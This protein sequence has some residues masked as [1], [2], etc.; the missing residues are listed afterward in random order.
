MLALGKSGE[1]AIVTFPCNNHYRQ[2]NAMWERDLCAFSGY[3]MGKLEK[4]NE[5]SH[6]YYTNTC[7]YSLLAVSYCFYWLMDST[8]YSQGRAGGAYMRDKS[9][10]AGT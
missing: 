1:R 2:S 7:S 5:V 4:N 9:T 8:F 6:F 3:L 10:Y